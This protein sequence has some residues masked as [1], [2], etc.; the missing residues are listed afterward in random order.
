MTLVF[1]E[2]THEMLTEVMKVVALID[3]TGNTAA[4]VRKKEQIQPKMTFKMLLNAYFKP[5]LQ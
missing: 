3:I 1:D 4:N 2:G 5:S